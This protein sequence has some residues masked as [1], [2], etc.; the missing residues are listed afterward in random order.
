MCSPS[1]QPWDQPEDIYRF[2]FLL[3]LLLMLLLQILL[4]IVPAPSAYRNASAGFNGEK[5]VVT[6]LCNSRFCNS[7]RQVSWCRWALKTS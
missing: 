6:F 4:Y 2:L 7:G 1:I 3:L 5:D